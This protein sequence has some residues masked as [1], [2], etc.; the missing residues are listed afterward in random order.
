M[1]VH[2]LLTNSTTSFHP[3]DKGRLPPT[4]CKQLSTQPA[5]DPRPA[6]PHRHSRRVTRSLLLSRAIPVHPL[7]SSHFLPQTYLPIHQTAPRIQHPVSSTISIINL[8]AS[9]YLIP[10]VHRPRK[11]SAS[12]N[13]PVVFKIPIHSIELTLFFWLRHRQGPNNQEQRD[14]HYYK[15]PR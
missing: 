7:T 11:N 10:T 6:L 8:L 1:L 9:S 12:L 4:P 14:P 2:L 5:Q 15:D 3:Q 13:L